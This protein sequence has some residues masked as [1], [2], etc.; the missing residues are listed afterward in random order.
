MSETHIPLQ[1]NLGDLLNASANRVKK[2]KV[3]VKSQN[4]ARFREMFDKGEVPEGAGGAPG[5]ALGAIAEKEQELEMMRKSKRDQKE[6]FQKLE[7]GEFDEINDKPKAWLPDGYS[8][9]LRLYVF[10]PSGLKDYGSATL[11]CKI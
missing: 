9:I 10:G 7:R 1:D 6:F 5:T 2:T 11:R 8:Q 3:D 4:A